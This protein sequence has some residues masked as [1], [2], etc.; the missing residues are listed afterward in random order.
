M[1]EWKVGLTNKGRVSFFVG[2]GGKT[3]CHPHAPPHPPWGRVRLPFSFILRSLAFASFFYF[4]PSP[5]LLLCRFVAFRVIEQKNL[6]QKTIK[7]SACR[8]KNHLHKPSRWGKKGGVSRSL[9]TK[10][11][12]LAPLEDLGQQRHEHARR[13]VGLALDLGHEVRV[14]GV[15]IL[16]EGGFQF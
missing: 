16:V 1:R 3:F 2:F 11:I 10:T 9:N 6:P 4:F 7:V 14:D 8:W 12:S 13:H 15:F 5:L